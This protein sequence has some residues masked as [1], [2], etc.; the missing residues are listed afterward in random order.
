MNEWCKK[1]TIVVMLAVAPFLGWAI[2]LA[3]QEQKIGGSM[4]LATTTSTVDSGLLDALV[5]KFRDLTGID[6]KVIGVGTGAS[7]EMAARGNADAALTHAPKA[8]QDYVAAGHLVDGV[9]VMHNDFIIIGPPDDPAKVKDAK[10]LKDTLQRI[11]AAGTFISR[12]DDSGTHKMELGLWKAASISLKAMKKRE[13]TGQGMGATLNVADQKRGYTLTDRG[14]YLA[15]K[16]KLNL[17]VVFEGETTLLNIYHAY[18][19]NPQKHDGIKAQ[20]ARAFVNFLVS[21]PVQQFIGEFRKQEFG[22]SLF[23]P[24]AGKSLADLAKR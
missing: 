20:Q 8:E 13:E 2:A 11:A 23:I 5:P 10:D 4:I 16:Q 9:L 12:G 17:E 18:V 22:E 6:V 19:V 7:L 21:P 24:D 3:N 14:T 1:L 15:L